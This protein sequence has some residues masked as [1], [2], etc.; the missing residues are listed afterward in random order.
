M[1]WTLMEDSPGS[2]KAYIINTI[3]HTKEFTMIYLIVECLPYIFSY[4][5]S[6]DWFQKYI[7][8]VNVE[9]F[10]STPLQPVVEWNS[11]QNMDL[12]RST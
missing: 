9:I 4:F 3:L 5:H 2:W 6:N 12:K 8:K 10:N 1:I 11:P 7:T